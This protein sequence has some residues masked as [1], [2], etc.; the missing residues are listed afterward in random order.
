MQKYAKRA[1]CRDSQP[2]IENIDS[3][4]DISPGYASLVDLF[5]LSQLNNRKMFQDSV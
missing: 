2:S 4:L 3:L 5:L 1:T